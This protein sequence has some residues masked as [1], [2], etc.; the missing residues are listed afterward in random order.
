MYSAEPYLSQLEETVSSVPET[1]TSEECILQWLIHE[2]QVI[3]SI[4][5]AATAELPAPE[6]IEVEQLYQHKLQMALEIALA[7]LGVREI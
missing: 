1:C 2:V 3:Q 7:T 6:A 5:D 4:Y